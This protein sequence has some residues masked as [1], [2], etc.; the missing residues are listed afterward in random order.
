M[1]KKSKYEAKPEIRTQVNAEKPG[2]W[3]AD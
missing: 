3:C 2:P 1:I